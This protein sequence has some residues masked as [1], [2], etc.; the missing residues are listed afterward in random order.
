MRLIIHNQTIVPFPNEEGIDVAIG[1]QTNVA[2]SRTFIKKL[3]S[4]Y[5]DCLSE[6]T[7]E[8]AERNELIKTIFTDYPFKTYTQRYCMKVCYQE[9]I[10][11]MKLTNYY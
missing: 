11:G 10:I 2:I 7:S 4:P 1:Y 9:Y 5:S 6:L 3:P 8:T